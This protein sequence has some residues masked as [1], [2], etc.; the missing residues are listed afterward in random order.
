MDLVGIRMP[1]VSTVS[2]AEGEFGWPVIDLPIKR[3]GLTT[4]YR[5]QQSEFRQL[6][7]RFRPDV[8]HAQGIDVPGYIAVRSG[9]PAVVTVHGI[10]SEETRYGADLRTRLR[11]YLNGLLLERP[12]VRQATDLISI[13]PYVTAH[14]GNLI[15]G[16]IHD[17]PNAIASKYFDVQRAPERGR[18]LFA[19][20][21]I[22]RKG[23][24]DLVRAV[25]ECDGHAFRIVIAGAATEPDYER[26]LREQAGRLGVTERIDFRGLLDET[27]MLQEFSRAEALVLPSYQE[28]APMVIQQ[29]MAAGLA[30]IATRICGVPH[31]VTDGVTGLL[32]EAGDVKALANLLRR[33]GMDS[34]LSARLGE[35]GR[36]VAL[37]RYHATSVASA[38]VRA[39]E[40]CISP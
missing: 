31:Q 24:L 15:R 34:G 25:A 5:R 19:G 9:I 12:T 6:L 32:Y 23:V 30:V 20:R 33:L 37:E 29:A 16:R 11:S 8:I 13:S 3:W 14:Y 40:Q 22:K 1:A 4:A 17:I 39:Y 7:D 21:V 36:R 18:L 35:A 27:S 28:T 38:T 2:E 26:V 10:L